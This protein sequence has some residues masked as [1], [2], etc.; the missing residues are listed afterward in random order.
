MT[1][2]YLLAHF[3]IMCNGYTYED[4]YYP[5]RKMTELHLM[6]IISEKTGLTLKEVKEAGFRIKFISPGQ[7]VCEDDQEETLSIEKYIIRKPRAK[8]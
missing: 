5:P 7:I 8:Y 3:I 6:E 4:N 1:I 2:Y